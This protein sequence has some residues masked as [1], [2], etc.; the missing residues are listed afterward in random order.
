MRNKIIFIILAL[1]ALGSWAEAYQE[2]DLIR[3]R[4]RQA[5]AFI[6]QKQFDR[7]EAIY[8]NLLQEVPHNVTVI[9]HLVQFYL[10]Q[11]EFSKLLT[12]LE[13]EKT[14]LNSEFISLIHIEI[15]LKKGEISSA[16]KKVEDMIKDHPD[17]QN[18]YRTIATLYTRYAHFEHAIQ[19]YREARGRFDNPTLY[20]RELALL[21]EYQMNFEAAIEEYLNILDRYSYSFIKY[22]LEQL[23]VENELIVEALQKRTESSENVEMKS[24]LGEFLL[25]GKNYDL[26]FEVFK[27]LGGNYLLNFAEICEKQGLL[28]LS[29]NTYQE[30]LKQ[31]PDFQMKLLAY[32][33]IGELYRKLH[34]EESAYNAYMH[35]LELYQQNSRMMPD[36]VMQ[37]ALSNLAELEIILHDNTEKSRQFLQRAQGFARSQNDRLKLS[38]LLAESYLNDKEFDR[39]VEI[40]RSILENQKIS[41][42]IKYQTKYKLYLGYH[43][44]DNPEKADSVFQDVLTYDQNS[45]YLNDMVSIQTFLQKI[46][47]EQRDSVIQFLGSMISNEDIKEVEELYNNLLSS[48]S[49]SWRIMLIQKEMADCYYSN[50]EYSKAAGLYEKLSQTVGSN[51]PVGGY[52]EYIY[53]RLGDCYL[54]LEEYALAEECYKQFLIDFPTSAFAPEVRMKLRES[55]YRL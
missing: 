13:S 3:L 34:E 44:A 37:R 29:I 23:D 27:E 30:I 25:R 53:K 31:K 12:L 14:Y 55:Q 38:I 26:A 18:L 52:D 41:Q 48:V 45:N 50:F 15:D 49:A 28:S 42:D 51:P 17:D 32:E 22:R 47:G 1:L 36:Q 9:Q 10:S 16:E 2:D 6:R 21:Y 5:D 7:A 24:L 43:Y 39:A 4:L 8:K 40:Y 33:R 20:A 11:N 54:E 19:I 35:I 46:T